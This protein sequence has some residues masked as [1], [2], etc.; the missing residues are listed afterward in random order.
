ML[1]LSK[2]KKNI[3]FNQRFK[4]ILEVLKSIAVSQFHI[5][6]KKLEL[7]EPFDRALH[8]FFASIDMKKIVHPFLKPTPPLGVV[9]VSSDQGLLG[10]LNL[11]VINAATSLIQTKQDQLIVIGEQG[12]HYAR[13]GKVPFVAFPGVHDE[14]RYQQA[15]EIRDYLFQRI[16]EKQIGSI[17]VVYPRAF[18][19]VNQK[20]EAV[21]LLPLV[22]EESQLPSEID[23]SQIVFESS[24]ECILE[25]L[26]H[27]W[28]GQKLNEFFGLSRLAELGARYI[29][30]E[31]SSQK[32]QDMN[33]KLKL[34]Y[35]K[36]RHEAIDQ[37]MRELFSA[38]SLYAD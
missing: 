30:L 21:M 35:F 14:T 4:S 2:V 12:K 25:Y 8:A 38:R 5:L 9:A 6:E 29:H 36:L 17:Q 3:E 37:S 20:V 13:Y 10:G 11:R 27:L 24:P 23:W 31:E 7:Y 1:A 33:N 32:I 18:S 26:A 22:A 28:V 16:R 15:I 19:L 34:Q